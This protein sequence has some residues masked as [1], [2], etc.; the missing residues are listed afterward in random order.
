[1]VFNRNSRSHNRTDVNDRNL[2]NIYGDATESRQRRRRE[3]ENQE[4]QKIPNQRQQNNR[5]PPMPD[6]PFD[7]LFGDGGFQF[8]NFGQ[9]GP[10]SRPSDSRSG[11]GP[12]RIN[13][14]RVN[15]DNQQHVPGG[16]LCIFHLLYC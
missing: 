16:I 7:S 10:P 4:E 2:T 6:N 15:T 12:T 14:T 13:L 3:A 11:N 9:R 8:S 5:R 1:M